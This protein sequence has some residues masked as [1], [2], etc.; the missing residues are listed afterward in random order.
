MAKMHTFA[1]TTPVRPARFPNNSLAYGA[2]EQ[3]FRRIAL[4]RGG[5]YDTD[6]IADAYRQ[7]VGMTID[8]L[9]GTV[10]TSLLRR[11]AQAMLQGEVS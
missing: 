6:M 8:T 2:D 9:A 1:V 3:Y 5:G 4:D 7:Q 10:W 11:F